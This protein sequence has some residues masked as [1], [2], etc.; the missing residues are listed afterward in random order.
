[1]IKNVNGAG[2]KPQV[3]HP[4]FC[5]W[6]TSFRVTKEEKQDSGGCERP[7]LFL[8]PAP[9]TGFLKCRWSFAVFLEQMRWQHG[10][11]EKKICVRGFPLCW[12]KSYCVC[13]MIPLSD[14][15]M[16]YWSLLYQGQF[17]MSRINSSNMLFDTERYIWRLK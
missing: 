5:N 15:T 6:T 16:M 8:S 9:I 13:T 7:L 11:Q 14:Q 2:F 1:M 10:K 3:G 12:G 4:Y 17:N